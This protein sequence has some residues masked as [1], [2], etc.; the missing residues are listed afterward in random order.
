MITTKLNY[1]ILITRVILIL[2]FI[3]PICFVNAQSRHLAK[4]ISSNSVS[5]GTLLEYYDNASL[6]YKFAIGLTGVSI[7]PPA[8]FYIKD[9]LAMSPIL[10]IE[11]TSGV[12]SLTF[13]SAD[14]TTNYGIYQ[15]G[16]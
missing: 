13:L 12:N 16:N 14:N 2:L 1:N 15:R 10:K 6:K 4:F 11:E 3:T 5:E 7:N 9:A 8:T